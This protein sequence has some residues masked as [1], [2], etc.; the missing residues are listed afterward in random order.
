[1]RRNNDSA[2]VGTEREQ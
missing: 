2:A 1:M